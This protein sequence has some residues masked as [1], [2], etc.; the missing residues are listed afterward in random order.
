ML[1]YMSRSSRG[2]SVVATLRLRVGQG[3]V[4][5]S[6]RG[7]RTYAA[8]GSLILRMTQKS[9]ASSEWSNQPASIEK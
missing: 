1:M 6:V 3:N 8:S 5:D 2:E 9:E 4:M 7:P